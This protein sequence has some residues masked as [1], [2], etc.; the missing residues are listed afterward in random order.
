MMF[1]PTRMA[2][3]LAL[4]AFLAVGLMAGTPA[5]KASSSASAGPAVWIT[6][7][8]ATLTGY[9][10]PD[11]AQNSGW[12]FQYG[13][14]TGY[15]SVT[16]EQP[17]SGSGQQTVS[18]TIKNLKPST[19]YHYRLVVTDQS[20]YSQSYV[21]GQDQTFTTPADSVATTGPAS[22]ITSASATLNGAS[23]A[24]DSDS[25][26]T[27]TYGTTTA[28]GKATPVQRMGS[29]LHAVSATIAGLKPNTTYHYRLV[30]EQ[31]SY[32]TA[33]SYGADGTFVT[34]GSGSS[35]N[36]RF[37]RASLTTRRLIVRKGV[38]TITF[39]CS[40]SKG[41]RCAGAMTLASS[42]TVRKRLK[43]ITCGRATLSMLA[44]HTRSINARLSTTCNALLA[45]SPHHRHGAHLRLVF[46]T[47]QLPLR[48]PV[49]LVRLLR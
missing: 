1:R 27:F 41:A 7:T 38:V 11:S 34:K 16:P 48:V 36:P 19:T 40:G 2:A 39:K 25:A 18:Y 31:G 20:G 42:Q 37:G 44:G 32:N 8:G 45:R 23:N 15:G 14:S 3:G 12:A 33:Y 6:S 29:G 24:T 4:V 49:T 22:S 10:T 13:T 5:A 21:L 35:T 9:A 28:Y 26:W 43:T 47:H 17:F 46:T 30:V